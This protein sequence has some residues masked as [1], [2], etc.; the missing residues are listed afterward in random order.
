VTVLTG[1]SP[2]REMLARYAGLGAPTLRPRFSLTT[3]GGGSCCG[4]GG[5]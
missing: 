5:C 4:G 2:T 1:S 3:V